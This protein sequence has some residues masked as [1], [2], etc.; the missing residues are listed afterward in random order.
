MELVDRFE[1]VLKT[2]DVERLVVTSAMLAML[3]RADPDRDVPIRVFDNQKHKVY[4]FKLSS[5]KRGRYEKPV[6]QSRGWRVFVNDRGIAAGDV[7]YFWE[8]EYPIEG[9]RYRIALY[10]PD[11]FPHL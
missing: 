8:E 6:F 2:S 4:E 11:L 1:K 10:K 3:P 7:L 5:R 9:T